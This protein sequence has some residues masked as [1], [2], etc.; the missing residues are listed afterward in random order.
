MGNLTIKPASGGLLKLQDAGST[1]RIQITDGGSTVLYEDDGNAALT[2]DTSGNATIETGNL[3]IGTAGQG[4]TFQDTD[5]TND[6]STANEA[7][8]LD[9]YETGTWTCSVV[10]QTATATGRYVKIGSLVHIEVFF[11]CDTNVSTIT[12]SNVITGLP[13]SASNTTRCLLNFFATNLSDVS[14]SD[15]APT[16]SSSIGPPFVLVALTA[17]SIRPVSSTSGN[18]YYWENIFSSTSSFYLNGTYRIA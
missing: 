14:G 5:A 17:G 9:S 4:I 3:V 6:S 7:Y 1:D 11:A 13:F 12:T 16:I 2:I 8:T 10:G 15:S 18:Q